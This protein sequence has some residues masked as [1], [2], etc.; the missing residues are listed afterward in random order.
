M[1]YGRLKKK[2]RSSG[3]KHSY[4]NETH[5]IKQGVIHREAPVS[6]GNCHKCP[7]DDKILIASQKSP[8]TF[9]NDVNISASMT[10]AKCI[11]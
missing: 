7:L 11:G 10:S 1:A 9:A 3:V 4:H 5:L 6:G 2:M 8:N